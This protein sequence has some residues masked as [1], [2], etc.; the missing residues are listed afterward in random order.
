MACSLFDEMI[1]AGC[2]PNIVTYNILLDCLERRGKTGEA[3]K[4]YE[5]LKQQGLTPDSI[6]YSILERLESRSQRTVRIRK[7][8]RTTGWV[9]SPV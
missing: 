4:L 1:A 2:V 6:T 5:T 9:V 8:S 3:H 7:P